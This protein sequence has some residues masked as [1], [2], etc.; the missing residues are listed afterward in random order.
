MKLTCV[1]HDTGADNY[2][3]NNP[4]IINDLKVLDKQDCLTLCDAGHHPHLSKHGGIAQ[5]KL[6]DGSVKE[7]FMRYTPSMPVTV[8]N[9][10]KM[11]CKG[12]IC[13][14]E[15]QWIH[16]AKKKYLDMFGHTWF[17]QDIASCSATTPWQR[18]KK[19]LYCPLLFWF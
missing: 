1:L 18:Y 6:E 11:C 7:F 10:T 8:I 5:L 2:A 3:M 12:K 16:H 13:V 9:V 4:F 17:L 14:Q 15:E 19:I